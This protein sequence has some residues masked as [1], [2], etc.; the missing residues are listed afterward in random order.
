MTCLVWRRGA[1]RELAAPEAQTL[2]ERQADA[3]EEEHVLQ[4][5]VVAQ[6]VAL[7]ERLVQVAHAHGERFQ[8]QLAYPT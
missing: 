7:L 8:R 6:V 2:L 5:A 3:L 4:A 1:A